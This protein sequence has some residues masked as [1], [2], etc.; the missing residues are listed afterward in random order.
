MTDA[1]HVAPQRVLTR[2]SVPATALPL[3]PRPP[4]PPVPGTGIPSPK[5]ETLADAITF[6]EGHC[7]WNNAC[8]SLLK[9]CVSSI[10]RTVIM[11]RARRSGLQVD[12][13]HI[14]LARISFDLPAINR[15]LE[16]QTYRQAGF[17][18][19]K[20]F[21]N[22]KWGFRRVCR[23]MGKITS[24]H[25]PYLP[26]DSPYMAFV[27]AA[28]PFSRA[29]AVRFACE[30]HHKGVPPELMDDARV[31]EYGD[32]LRA[33]MVGVK[34][35]VTLRRI[36]R[37]WNKVARRM[38][39]RRLTLPACKLPPASPPMSTYSAAVQEE[40][41]SVRRWMEGGIVPGMTGCDPTR[42]IGNGRRPAR[43][44]A[45]VKCRMKYIR[46]S[47]G[48][49][50]SLG[51]DPQAMLGLRC[52]LTPEVVRAILQALWERGQVRRLTLPE[53]ECDH[54]E[55]GLTY[56][57]NMAAQTLMILANY[58]FPQPPEVLRELRE[59]TR[60][61]RKAVPGEMTWKNQQRLR[62]FE[63]PVKLGL[64]LNLANDLMVEAMNLRHT[65]P[66]E[67]ARRGRTAIIFAIECRIPLRIQ[68]LAS[69][70]IG[71]N[72]RFSGPASEVVTLGFQSHEMKNKLAVE[73]SV[74]PRLL[75]LLQTYIAHFLPFFAEGSPD[76]ADKQWLFPADR[77]R[78]GH[79]SLSQ[80]R[81]II[82]DAMAERVGVVFH[83]HL[84]RGLAVSLSLDHAPGSLEHA[85]QLLGDK[86]M[87]TV[88][89][90]YATVRRK[91]AARHQ[92]KIVEAEA[93]R[94]AVLAAATRRRGRKG[95]RS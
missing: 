16:G 10:G 39:W 7:S 54:D 74:G 73:Y 79:L 84:F 29:A 71:Y 28:T 36:L 18:T 37:P 13:K 33:N 78:A 14:D 2:I 85:R 4:Q 87:E 88:T 41:A 31:V 86:T 45:T 62:Q 24:K 91:E 76:F 34:V 30:Y 52:L 83:P 27:K 43:R 94:L 23:E 26:P 20:S 49:Y 1:N 59:L 50:V 57:M 58:C 61:A 42:I 60:Q 11:I 8:K 90:H 64:L 65:Q 44:P 69:S 75:K 92:D 93:Q 70:R 53:A 72:L 19:A 25:D 12:L 55:T 9:T 82:C 5:A 3:V 46:L 32:S 67:A 80:M 40:A 77:G 95:G 15:D 56:Q 17:N 63:D 89:R 6:I 38:R 51:H 22:T 68:N 21:T 47:L 66:A 35:T 81:D 48:V